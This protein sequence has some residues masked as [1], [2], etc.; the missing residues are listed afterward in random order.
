[1]LIQK[2]LKGDK[3]VLPRIVKLAEELKNIREEIYYKSGR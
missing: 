2:F 1:L 3:S